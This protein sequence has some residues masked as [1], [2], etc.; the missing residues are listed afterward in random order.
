MQHVHAKFASFQQNM[1]LFNG[2]NS[3][4]STLSCNFWFYLI[5]KSVFGVFIADFYVVLPS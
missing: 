1:T 5:R 3:Y 4:E 2:I